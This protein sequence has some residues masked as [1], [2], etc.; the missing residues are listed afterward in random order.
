MNEPG[1]V[2]LLH[3]G[4]AGNRMRRTNV[5]SD[6]ADHPWLPFQDIRLAAGP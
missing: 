3:H 2:Q 6:F 1:R 4:R 5:L